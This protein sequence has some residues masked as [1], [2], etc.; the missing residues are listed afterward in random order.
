MNTNQNITAGDNFTLHLGDNLATLKNYPAD[1]FD[2]IVTDPPYG[3]DFLGKEWDTHT[4]TVELYK[5]CLRVLKPGGYLL[6]FSAARTYHKL[7]YSVEL[8]GFEIRDQLMWLYS[9]GFPKAQDIGKAID[10]RGNDGSEWEGYK[11]ALKPAHEPIVMARKPYKGS[12]IDQ[13]LKNGLGALNIDATRVPWADAK[14]VETHV[15]WTEAYLEAG[16]GETKYDNY[17]AAEGQNRESEAKELLKKKKSDRPKPQP[18]NGNG[19]VIFQGTDYVPAADDAEMSVV[20]DAGRYPSN[21]I[22]EVAEGYQKYFYC[23]KVSRKERHVGF[24]ELPP[25]TTSGMLGTDGDWKNNDSL[26]EG[27]KNNRSSIG[28]NHPTVKPVALMEYLIKLVTPPSTPTLQRKVLDPFMGSGST[29]MAAVKLG[30]HFTGCELDPKYVAI[31]S[32][33]IEAWQVKD[34]DEEHDI[35]P[36]NPDEDLPINTLFTV[37]A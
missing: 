36:D 26:T 1:T 34:I 25:A 17:F 30:H 8:A 32:T 13:V 4:G 7:A 21:V 12:T 24:T 33:R 37:S 29:G 6:A 20:S 23:P 16:R 11:T 3:I 18:L 27:G 35:D 31:A 5:E 10:K 28:N 22:G 19:G 2:S 9:S 14:D 15:K